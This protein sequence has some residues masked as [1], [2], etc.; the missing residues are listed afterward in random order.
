MLKTSLNKVITNV[1]L[2][3]K[4]NENR[5][6]LTRKLNIKDEMNTWSNVSIRT[7]DC[8]HAFR[9]T[10]V[11]QEL[12]EPK[13]GNMGF[14]IGIQEDDVGLHI[15]VEDQRRAI[16]V[17]IAQAL[18][19]FHSNLIPCIPLQMPSFLPMENLSKAPIGHIL[20]NQKIR[21]M[22]RTK[23]QQSHNVPMPDPAKSLDLRRKPV[24]M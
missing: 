7:G 16:M 2:S 13:I 11:L 12:G 23:A 9:S 21:L 22:V 4:S 15:A 10:R 3:P 18:G 6:V 24:V 20:V 8:R 1:N 19:R 5:A 14:K 17:E